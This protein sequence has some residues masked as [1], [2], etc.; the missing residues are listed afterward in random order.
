MSFATATETIPAIVVTPA[1]PSRASLPSEMRVILDSIIGPVT[2]NEPRP[3]ANREDELFRLELD[4]SHARFSVGQ[5][6]AALDAACR[7]VTSV[8]DCET[9]E[10]EVAIGNTHDTTDNIPRAQPTSMSVFS[11][12]D[13][14]LTDQVAD[15]A[16][17]C[18][19]RGS[20][21]GEDGHT[22]DRSASPSCS[23]NGR[24]DPTWRHAV[25]FNPSVWPA[26][27][28]HS[29]GSEVRK[30]D[31]RSAS[32]GAHV[33]SGWSRMKLL[34]QIGS[35]GWDGMVYKAL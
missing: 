7:A 14:A 26:A 3:V 33:K 32:I 10:E 31:S 24:G 6:A 11:L 22:L 9:I 4:L 16:S 8:S 13:D 29:K 30:A 27:P 5:V 34:I 15:E 25:Y 35:G 23:C 20:L 2:T 21:D 19:G 28:D 18:T 12:N 17:C 1:M